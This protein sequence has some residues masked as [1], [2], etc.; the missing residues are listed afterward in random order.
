[1]PY[2]PLQALIDRYGATLLADWTDRGAPPTGSF[3][4][5][6]IARAQ[7][8]ADALIDGYLGGRYALPLAETPPLLA[9]LA[10]AVVAWKLNRYEPDPKI[11]ADYDGALRTL[12]DIARGTVRLN[13]AGIEVPGT[14]GTGA[15]ITDRRRAFTEDNL[16]GFI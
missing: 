8:D 16:R 11:R 4:A 5:D 15:R 3:D 12:A 9:D 10:C 6:V 14:G 2:A 1:V 13:L 7:A